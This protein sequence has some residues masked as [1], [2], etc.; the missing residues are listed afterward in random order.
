M[1][2]FI[3]FDRTEEM[4]RYWVT[5]STVVNDK[6]PGKIVINGVFAKIIR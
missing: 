4:E 3:F 6:Y 2:K 5:E 1:V